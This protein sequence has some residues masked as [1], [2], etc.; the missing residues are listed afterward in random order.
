M[1]TKLAKNQLDQYIEYA[2]TLSCHRDCSIYPSYADTIKTIDDFSRIM[3]R[4]VE[5]ENNEILLYYKDECLHGY[6]HYYWDDTDKNLW[7]YCFSIEKDF[8]EDALEEFF[9]TY[10]KRYQGY[11][12]DF[13]VSTDNQ[14]AMTY[15][16]SHQ[17][18]LIET[19]DVHVLHFVEYQN[20][21]KP[22]SVIKVTE[23]NYEEFAQIHQLIDKDMYWNCDR[24]RQRVKEHDS[25]WHLFFYQKNQKTVAAA[26][27][28]L[29][30]KSS[31]GEVFSIA[32]ASKVDSQALQELLKAMF[33]CCQTNHIKHFINFVDEDNELEKR[34]LEELGI[35]RIDTYQ[36]YRGII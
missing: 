1:L 7:F 25:Q 9:S 21:D 3:H 32:Y 14:K 2:H 23:E 16:Y 31:M 34:M 17:W 15:L 35:H 30:E 6:I 13:G 20:N 8:Y 26:C 19:A 10:Q 36:L 4:Y 29:M 28:R 18:N 11:N 24:L 12:V 22:T 27:L 5:E 33:D